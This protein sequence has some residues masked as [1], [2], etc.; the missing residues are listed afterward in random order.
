L[1]TYII[2]LIIEWSVLYAN[3]EK[4]VGEM[5]V[6]F[7]AHCVS[8]TF[9]YDSGVVYKGG[10]RDG[11]RHGRGVMYHASGDVENDEWVD[12]VTKSLMKLLS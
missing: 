4:Y 8:G 1:I 6:G 7:Q 2:S 3:N 5:M 12:G 10:W 9:K 11:V